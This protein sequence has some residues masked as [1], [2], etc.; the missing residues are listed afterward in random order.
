MHNSQQLGA[1]TCYECTCGPQHLGMQICWPAP[2]PPL[3]APPAVSRLAKET[4]WA[5]RKM[6]WDK[7]R[8]RSSDLE[9]TPESATELSDA[10]LMIDALLLS[11]L[12]HAEKRPKGVPRTADPTTEAEPNRLNSPCKEPRLKRRWPLTSL[13]TPHP[14]PN[15]LP[16]SFG[17]SKLR[18]G[19]SV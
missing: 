3:R 17:L 19:G 13:L 14:L 9:E 8:K 12:C 7:T 10:L 15:P 5:S 11:C 16:S 6:G 1:A 18:K 4:G 2:L